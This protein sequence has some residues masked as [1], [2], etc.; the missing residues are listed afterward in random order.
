MALRFPLWFAHSARYYAAKVAITDARDMIRIL[1]FIAGLMGGVS[2][3]QF[4]EFSQQ[5]LQRLA[6]AVDE[7]TR[8]VDDFDAS[9]EG[10][11]MSREQALAALSDGEFQRA[12][13]A[14]M[15]R[16]IAR[17][18]RLSGDLAALREASMMERALQ[19]Q[20]FTDTEIAAAAW[21]DF[22]P[23]V[24]VTST[25]L[26]FAI[27]GFLMAAVL[28]GVFLFSGRWAWR[29]VKPKRDY[30]GKPVNRAK[31]SEARLKR[32]ADAAAMPRELT[33]EIEPNL[34][35]IREAQRNVL[36]VKR[37]HE[38][39]I[40]E[41]AVIAIPAGKQLRL[42]GADG[43]DHVLMC[44]MGQ[45]TLMIGD[46]RRRIGVGELVMMPP[47]GHVTIQN[48]ADQGES[49]GDEAGAV[50]RLL[51]LGGRGTHALKD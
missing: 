19:P 11:G 43:A 8:V 35:V 46:E 10:V 18:E 13:Q 33:Y 23:A 39:R 36:P 25:G 17:Q 37:L 6:G 12:R 5:Y 28:F 14:D 21:E 47:A 26:I 24:P 48:P 15:T 50:L 3:S 45:G 31:P 22:Q 34:P 41:S 32:D 38:G 7:L 20:R 51:S 4:P 44:L 30:R 1:T 49:N 27:A 9:A 42:S 40:L 16:T 29:K 2:L